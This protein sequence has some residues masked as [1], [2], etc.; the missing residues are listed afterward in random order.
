MDM[1]SVHTVEEIV[2]SDRRLKVKGAAF[3][4]HLTTRK[5]MKGLD[6]WRVGEEG[7]D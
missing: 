7:K 1:F 2:V 4:I 6:S 5:L 3:A